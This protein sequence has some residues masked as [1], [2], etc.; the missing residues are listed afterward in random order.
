MAALAPSASGGRFS[1]DA[2]SPSIRRR[3]AVILSLLS[4]RVCLET[5]RGETPAV[6]GW[7]ALQEFR[8]TKDE[9]L[10]W[11]ARKG[12]K[13]QAEGLSRYGIAAPRAFGVPM[14]TLFSQAKRMEK[15]HEL[16]AALWE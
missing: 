4:G 14:G 11:L 15:D 8:M 3:S 2:A 16:A 7:P 13:R 10:A 5:P 1:S 6:L 9:V 12:T